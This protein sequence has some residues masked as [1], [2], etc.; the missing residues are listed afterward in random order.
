MS[1]FSVRDVMKVGSRMSTNRHSGR[2]LGEMER[3]NDSNVLGSD[4]AKST[5]SEGML[6]LAAVKAIEGEI[7]ILSVLR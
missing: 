4:E 3:S 6:G 2:E 5:P 7:P 1:N